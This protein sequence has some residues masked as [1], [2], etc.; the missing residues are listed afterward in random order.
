MKKIVIALLMCVV[1][2][3]C[4][5]RPGGG[6]HGGPHHGGGRGFGPGPRFHH[7]PPPVH[8]YHHDGS[9]WGRGGRNFWP[10]FVGGIVGGTVVSTVWNNPPVPV[11]VT[12]TVITTPIVT[13]TTPVYYG[14]YSETTVTVSPTVQQYNVTTYPTIYGTVVTPS[15]AAPGHYETRVD[16]WGN[17]STVW[18]PNNR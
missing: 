11:V 12:P 7:A 13:T 18:V 4:F 9:F 14:G 15:A 16:S 17:S 2:I 10:G 8:R 3:M 5:A 6:F 1:S